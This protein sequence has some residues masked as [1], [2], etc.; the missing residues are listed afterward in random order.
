M[1]SGKQ[2]KQGKLVSKIP[3]RDKSGNLKIWLKYQGK[4]REFEI[5]H[6]ISGKNQILPKR[7]IPW[8]QY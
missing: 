8:G 5:D 3:C 2:G 4:I 7:V 1:G 6:K